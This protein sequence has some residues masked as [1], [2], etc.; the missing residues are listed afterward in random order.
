MTTTKGPLLDPGDGDDAIDGMCVNDDDDDELDEI[1]HAMSKDVR[2][3]DGK[4]E[5]E[6]QRRS[7]NPK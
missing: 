4:D 3:C 2:G 6:S 5:A 1:L 7:L